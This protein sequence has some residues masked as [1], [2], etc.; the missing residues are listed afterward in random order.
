MSYSQAIYDKIEEYFQE[1]GWKYRFVEDKEYFRAGFNIDCKLGETTL[2]V[3][4]RDTF[5]TV[6]ATIKV[7]ADSDCRLAVAEYLTRANYGLNW[8]N[9]EMDMNDG[10]IRYKIL[11]DCG[12]HCECLPSNTV[13]ENSIV[14]AVQMMKKYGD[15]LLAVMYGFKTPEQACKDAEA[16]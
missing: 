6:H 13:F 5:Y 9:F 15:G 2:M 3:R 12:D 11:V 1:F 14:L 7:N 10:E 8:G 4:P 16:K